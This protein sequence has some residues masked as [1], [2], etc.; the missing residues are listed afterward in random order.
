MWA[1]NFAIFYKE[2]NNYTQYRKGNKKYIP[3][4]SSVSPNIA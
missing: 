4:G 1:E 3:H 2:K